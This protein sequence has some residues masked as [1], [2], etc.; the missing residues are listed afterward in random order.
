MSES[1][2]QTDVSNTSRAHSAYHCS[3]RRQRLIAQPTWQAQFAEARSDR[4]V[5]SGRRGQHDFWP[6]DVQPRATGRMEHETAFEAIPFASAFDLQVWQNQIDSEDGVAGC[7][8]A[9]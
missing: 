9:C 1:S 8:Y 6:H 4:R 5:D 7:L 2:R 3:A